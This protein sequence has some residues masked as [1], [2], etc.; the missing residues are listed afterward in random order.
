MI[1]RT[2]L[3]NRLTDQIDLRTRKVFPTIDEPLDRGDY[4]PD[5]EGDDAVIFGWGGGMNVSF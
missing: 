3:Q 4:E 2:N 1:P 5:E